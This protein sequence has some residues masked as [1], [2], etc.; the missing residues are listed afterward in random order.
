MKIQLAGSGEDR[1]PDLGISAQGTVFGIGIEA[2]FEGAVFEE[3]GA[4]ICGLIAH[5]DV[6][7]RQDVVQ[8]PSNEDRAA[9]AFGP[10][11]FVLHEAISG[12]ARAGLGDIDAGPL[13]FPAIHLVPH[14]G[15]V[16]DGDKGLGG[17]GNSATVS[18][19]HVVFD[20]VAAQNDVG[21][22]RGHVRIRMDGTPGDEGMV[23]REFVVGDQR[24]GAERKHDGAP[25]LLSEVGDELVSIDED[26][27][28]FTV[29][30]VS[31]CVHLGVG[32]K[33]APII[34]GT[35]AFK[36]VV[37]QHHAGAMLLAHRSAIV[38][39]IVRKGV[40]GDH[41][42]AP[43]SGVVDYV[44]GAP[45]GNVLC[46]VSTTVVLESVALY[47]GATALGDEYSAAGSGIAVCGVSTEPVVENELM[48]AVA[49]G[50]CSA[51]CVL[52]RGAVV[53]KFIFPD[54]CGAVEIYID[55]S[56]DQCA[57]VTDDVVADGDL[58]VVLGRD[59]TTAR[60]WV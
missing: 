40:A 31:P 50:Y 38:G 44:N 17:D 51:P 55:T 3:Q 9:R 35:V 26:V 2:G 49:R 16:L 4:A 10:G 14:K 33:G 45:R 29:Y 6:V 24:L 48:T 11:A 22:Y 59:C 58:H 30:V 23:V 12:N 53:E 7:F 43:R 13:G 28:Q 18:V 8:C 42:P 57:V 47:G 60:A 20:Q 36:T 41:D 34:V 39:G 21:L 56:T 27:E 15:V 19:R 32:E 52:P 25:V 37:D 46:R 5:D 1:R 54:R